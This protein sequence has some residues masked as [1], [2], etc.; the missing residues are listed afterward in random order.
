MA[1]GGTAQ[2]RKDNASNSDRAEEERQRTGARLYDPERNRAE[3]G[4]RQERPP[5]MSAEQRDRLRQDFTLAQIDRHSCEL[6]E[7]DVEGLQRMVE[8]PAKMPSA[9]SSSRVRRRASSEVTE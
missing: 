7:M 1:G 5:R 3:R 8:I 2:P 6:E 4:G 9:A